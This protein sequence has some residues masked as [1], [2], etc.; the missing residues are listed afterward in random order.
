ME[1]TLTEILTKFYC[2]NDIALIIRKIHGQKREFI[3]L[4]NKL[5]DAKTRN[6]VGSSGIIQ[7]IVDK[8]VTWDYEI[9]DNPVKYMKGLS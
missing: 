4:N 8:D 9:V 7:L 1:K 3:F 2:S 5:F 6:E